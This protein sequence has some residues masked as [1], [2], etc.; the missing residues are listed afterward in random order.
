LPRP[1]KALPVEL[2]QSHEPAAA[3]RGDLVGGSVATKKFLLAKLVAR[4]QPG[5]AARHARMAAQR[6]VLRQGEVEARFGLAESGNDRGCAEGVKRE[7]DVARIHGAEIYPKN[8][9]TR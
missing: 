1:G 5:E 9:D 3:K 2:C 7:C 4:H 6:G 8:C